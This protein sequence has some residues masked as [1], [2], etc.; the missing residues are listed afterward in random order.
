MLLPKDTMIW[1][2][3]LYELPHGFL[4]LSI[5]YSNRTRIGL[6]VNVE[7]GAEVLG[8]YETSGIGKIMG[9]V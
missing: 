8:C 6:A 7:F 2:S 1:E 4:C 3:L 5:R 9:D